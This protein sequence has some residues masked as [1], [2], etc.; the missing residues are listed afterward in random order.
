MEP[1]AVELL[2]DL[3]QPVGVAVVGSRGALFQFAPNYPGK[4]G[5]DDLYY[6][7]ELA[8]GELPNITW[9]PGGVRIDF[10]QPAADEPLIV[11]R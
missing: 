8:I 1:K 5:D 7:R 3:E 6:G 11:D 4:T 10:S 2:N 9:I